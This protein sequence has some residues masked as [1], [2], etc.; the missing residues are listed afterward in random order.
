[1]SGFACW[2]ISATVFA[3]AFVPVLR[4]ATSWPGQRCGSARG[5]TWRRAGRWGR[6][7]SGGA[8]VAGPA[9]AVTAAAPISVAAAVSAAVVRRR[10]VDMRF[11]F[12]DFG[13]IG[14]V[15]DPLHARHRS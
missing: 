2:M 5:C 15:C 13:V 8:A 7:P 14:G 1:M 6:G 10:L 3:C 4:S 9:I 11:S 12:I